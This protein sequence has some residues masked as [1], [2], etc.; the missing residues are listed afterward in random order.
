VFTIE[1]LGQI[2]AAETDVIAARF[3]PGARILEVGAGTG[4]QAVAIRARGFEVEAIEI[5]ASNYKQHQL[6]P[7]TDYDGRH[8]PFPDA[9]FDVVFSSNVL[10]HVRDLAGLEGEI[11][12]VLR[13]GGV[14]VHVLPTHA[15]RFWTTLAAFPAAVQKV[16]A[17][18]RAPTRAGTLPHK[19]A[20]AGKGFV[21]SLGYLVQPF[22]QGRHGERGLLL[23]E[24]W[25]FRPE[26]W[27]RHFRRSGFEIVR[28]APM[29]LHYTGHF[30]FSSGWPLA[31]RARLA[32]RLGSACHLFELRVAGGAGVAAQASDGLD[33]R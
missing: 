11:K 3:P 4:Q 12:R 2:R 1:F 7:I 13:P 17:L 24:L 10:E 26:V 9:S 30:V 22:F 14:C 27:R 23:S 15:W 32:R 16:I 21:R 31:K 6:F 28:D 33:P 19:V 18:L 25:L 8:I 20:R 29:G 5:P